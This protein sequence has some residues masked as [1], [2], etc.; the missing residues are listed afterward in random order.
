M[1]CR[2]KSVRLRGDRACKWQRQRGLCMTSPMRERAEET[3]C[4]DMLGRQPF[5]FVIA[6][7]RK[8]LPPVSGMVK[9]VFLRGFSLKTASCRLPKL[10]H[11]TPNPLIA[12][13]ACLQWL[14]LKVELPPSLRPTCRCLYTR[15]VTRAI[16]STAQYTGP[17]KHKATAKNRSSWSLPLFQGARYNHGAPLLVLPLQ[18]VYWLQNKMP[19]P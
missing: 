5:L 18:G 7:K 16:H 17:A 6:G 13:S 11:P 12:T 15:E 2:R 1:C 4:L 8:L 9:V 14:Q 19:G 10:E 3:V